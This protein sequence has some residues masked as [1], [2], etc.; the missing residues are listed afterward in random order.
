MASRT[1]TRA[2]A[3]LFKGPVVDPK[4]EVTKPAVSITHAK[5]EHAGYTAELENGFIRVTRNSDGV[6]ICFARFNHELRKVQDIDFLSAAHQRTNTIRQP[7][8]DALSALE[9]KL[10]EI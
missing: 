4:A 6:T 9:R 7:V 10:S 1:L 2:R 3:M 5:I 8:C